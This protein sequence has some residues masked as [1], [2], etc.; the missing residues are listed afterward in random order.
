MA[1]LKRDG[2]ARALEL[3]RRSAGCRGAPHAVDAD[4]DALVEF[5]RIIFRVALGDTRALCVRVFRL[6]RARGCDYR[7]CDYDAECAKG[8]IVAHA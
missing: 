4:I 5:G 6:L 3:A 2:L 8:G 7:H 1:P